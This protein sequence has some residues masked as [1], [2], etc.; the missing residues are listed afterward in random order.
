MGRPHTWRR[1]RGMGV[2]PRT[3]RRRATLTIAASVTA[4]IAFVRCVGD[5]PAPVVTSSPVNE[6]GASSGNSGCSD[7]TFC[8]DKC[9]S[10]LADKCGLARNCSSCGDGRSCNGETHKCSCVELPTL[11]ENRCG[12]VPTNCGTTKEC[13]GC[14]GGPCPAIGN[15]SGCVPDDLKACGDRECGTVQNNCNQVVACGPNKG[16]CPSNKICS[17]SG[18]CCELQ[19]EV[20]KVGRCGS[21]T[22]A[23]GEAFACPTCP[24]ATDTCGSS[25]TCVCNCPN[26]VGNAPA[27]VNADVGGGL[28]K[29]GCACT[30]SNHNSDPTQCGCGNVMCPAG[31]GCHD[32]AC[33]P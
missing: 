13:G 20:C 22:A 30:T 23:C 8:D 11:C 17:A 1:D 2:K 33:V 18:K 5:D 4:L 31:W 32:G 7:P 12:S 14:D 28:F 10:G 25:G 3:D 19:S 21:V 9:G 24:S 6:A 29:P 27:C 15:C 26:L 16:Q